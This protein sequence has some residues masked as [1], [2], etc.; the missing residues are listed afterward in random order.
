MFAVEVE[1]E[2]K[3]VKGTSVNKDLELRNIMV[4]VETFKPIGVAGVG[5][6]EAGETER[7]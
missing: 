2:H 3:R 1:L 4:C 7:G 5:R 6:G